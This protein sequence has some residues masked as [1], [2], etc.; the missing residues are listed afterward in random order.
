MLKVFL[1]LLAVD[2]VPLGFFEG[3][4][5]ISDI[6]ELIIDLLEIV[7]VDLQALLVVVDTLVELLE[8]ILN[9]GLHFLALWG[10]KESLVESFEVLHL[11]GVSPSLG[12]GLGVSNYL[13]VIDGIPDLL[14]ISPFLGN[15]FLSGLG[16]GDFKEFLKIG[17]LLGFLFEDLSSSLSFLSLLDEVKNFFDFFIIR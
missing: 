7:I 3:F 2:G 4:H 8:D 14:N 6:G 16:D 11:F 9:L 5:L 17:V 1:H 13:R 15:C 12:G 10:G